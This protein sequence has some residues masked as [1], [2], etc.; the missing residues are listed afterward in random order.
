LASGT[1]A[2]VQLWRETDSSQ[3]EDLEKRT[4]SVLD[5]FRCSRFVF[6]K[7]IDNDC[8]LSKDSSRLSNGMGVISI[9]G[10]S[11][12][13]AIEGYTSIFILKLLEEG[14]L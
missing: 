1:V 4:I 12:K 7:I 14:S 9:G 8:L 6:S 3:K 10:T 2:I 5:V 11:C 13:R